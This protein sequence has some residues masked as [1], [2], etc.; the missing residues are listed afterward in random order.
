MNEAEIATLTMRPTEREPAQAQTG[1]LAP[2]RTGRGRRGGLTLV[3]EEQR[4]L[5]RC[6]GER[7]PAGLHGLGLPAVGGLGRRV[8]LPGRVA[9]WVLLRAGVGTHAGLGVSAQ[10]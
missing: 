1:A 3:G 5:V 4:L 2:S 10:G 8:V 7:D 9:G 6:E